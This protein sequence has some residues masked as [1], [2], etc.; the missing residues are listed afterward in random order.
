MCSQGCENSWSDYDDEDDQEEDDQEEVEKLILKNKDKPK[1]VQIL[2]D[3]FIDKDGQQYGPEVITGYKLILI[4]YTASWVSAN[5]PSK[6]MNEYL[7]ELYPK[8][9]GKRYGEKTFQI[10]AISGD[11]W[12]KGFR[13]TIKGI[14]WY[15]VPYKSLQIKIIQK[16][17]PCNGY[18]HPAVLCGTSGEVIH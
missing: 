15:F 8:W 10:I 17:V 14:P 6:A 18:P 11:S 7:E 1:L 4:L 12:R 9:N 2:G 13:E 16:V 5:K 3:H